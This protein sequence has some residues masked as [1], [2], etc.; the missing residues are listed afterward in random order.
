MKQKIYRTVIRFEIL[1]EEPIVNLP[2]LTEIDE[3]TT[4]GQWSGIFLDDEVRN[5]EL[6]GQAARA[7]IIS[8]GSDPEFFFM[9]DET[10]E[11]E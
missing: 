9:D 8:Q 7:K 6:T 1:S 10:E 11:G 2:S 4:S 5:E 3:E